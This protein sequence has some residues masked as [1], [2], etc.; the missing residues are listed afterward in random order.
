MKWNNIRIIG[1]AEG[2]EEEQEIQNLF[3]KVMMESIHNMMREKV[4]QI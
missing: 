3:Q 2:K 1:I 4:T